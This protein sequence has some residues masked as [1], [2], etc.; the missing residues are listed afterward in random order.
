MLIIKVSGGGEDIRKR[1]RA[2]IVRPSLYKDDGLSAG[3]LRDML[4]AL[5][6]NFG[7][8]EVPDWAE[9]LVRN[10]MSDIPDVHRAITAADAEKKRQLL[11]TMDRLTRARQLFDAWTG[12][13]N[14][15][16][17]SVLWGNLSADDRQFWLHRA[18]SVG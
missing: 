1:L 2:L 11:H 4:D 14:P 10:A 9:P 7:H 6:E 15:E 13:T 3:V 8:W 18:G 16:L 5:P 12:V 17:G